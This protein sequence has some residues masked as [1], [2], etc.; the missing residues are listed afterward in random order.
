VDYLSCC[1]GHGI[2]HIDLC[3]ERTIYGCASRVRVRVDLESGF[4]SGLW[5]VLSGNGYMLVGVLVCC[6]VGGLFTS[7]VRI[8]G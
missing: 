4:W 6:G 2:Y 7:D 5:L 3:L 1:F 8:R